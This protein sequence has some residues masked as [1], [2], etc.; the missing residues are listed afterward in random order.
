MSLLLGI[1]VVISGCPEMDLT[2][3]DPLP[4]PTEEDIAACKAGCDYLMTLTGQDGR[5][6]CKEARPLRYPDGTTESCETFCQETQRNGRSLNPK[7]WLT[8]QSCSEIEEK[9]RK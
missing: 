3:P 1:G 2:I 5:K 4:E 6:G 8:V 9:C 7:C